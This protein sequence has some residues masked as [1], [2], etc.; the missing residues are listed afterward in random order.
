[1]WCSYSLVKD[2]TQRS[3]LS[4]LMNGRTAVWLATIQAPLEDVDGCV[5]DDYLGDT[6]IPTFE[7]LVALRTQECDCVCRERASLATDS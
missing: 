2:D 4:N 5:I 6:L 7:E 1:M 3:A